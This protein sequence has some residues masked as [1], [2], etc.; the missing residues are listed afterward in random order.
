[1][2][3]T[4]SNK[5]PNTTLRMTRERIESVLTSMRY[6]LHHLNHD[7]RKNTKKT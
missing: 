1:M 4:H 6:V 7:L 3:K 5:Q 2:N